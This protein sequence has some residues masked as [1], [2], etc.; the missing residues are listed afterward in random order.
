MSTQQT[1]LFIVRKPGHSAWSEHTSLDEA[2]AE[3]QRAD[4]V[5][6]GHKVYRVIGDS[7]KEI[8]A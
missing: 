8:R 1:T 6:Q 3:R 2:L 7:V 4:N 5:L